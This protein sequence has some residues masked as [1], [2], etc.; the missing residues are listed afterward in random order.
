YDGN[1]INALIDFYVEQYDTVQHLFIKDASVS[2]VFRYKEA[3]QAMYG[4]Y[5]RTMGDFSFNIGLRAEAA[6]TNSILKTLDSNVRNNYFQLYP[7]IH[8]AYKKE[9][10]EWQLNYSRRVNR[11]DPDELNPFPEYIDPLNLRAGN[12]KLKPELIHSVEFGYQMNRKYFSFVPS[13]YYRYKYNGF[14]T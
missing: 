3:L 11:P 13:L 2:N 5:E 10:G 7:T 6:Y 9:K 8:L 1:F 14:T 12:P 4:T